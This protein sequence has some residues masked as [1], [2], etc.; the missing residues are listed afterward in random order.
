[1][2][3]LFAID[4]PIYG[5]ARTQRD[6]LIGLGRHGRAALATSVRWIFRLV[7]IVILVEAGLSINGAIIASIGASFV[8]ALVNRTGMGVLLDGRHGFPMRR[9]VGYAVPLFLASM[10]M[11]L[12]QRLDLFL[13]KIL[14]A[15]TAS[16]GAY[17]AAQNAA[18]VL[19]M[20]GGAMAPVI[21]SSLS[22]LRAS[23]EVESAQSIARNGLRA[24]TLLAPPVAL[25]A[26]SAPEI[27][28]TLFGP[29][30]EDGI[31]VLA[32]LSFSA[33]GL[34]FHGVGC[35]ALTASG[36]P[37]LV[38]ALTA[39]VPAAAVIGHLVAIPRYGMTGAAAVTTGASW[40][41][42]ILVLISVARLWRTW[43]SPATII[44]SAVTTAAVTAAALWWQ[45]SG[46]WI[47]VE[48]AVLGAA[49]G[50][51]LVALRE[52]RW[53]EICSAATALSLD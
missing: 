34:V 24:A 44:R 23:G 19:G 33:L 35:S 14:G 16:V 32:I 31:P 18:L 21:L 42:S 47:V 53:S 46:A 52:L 39:P 36:R 40:F 22:R 45:L 8:E 7:L 28:S 41:G 3:R 37:G 9:L 51:L 5:R 43:P 13:L 11:L 49:A 30:F 27:V 6:L 4:I 1:M 29:G 26:V 15:T 25:V 10:L 12:F 2:L 50:V 38:L 48:L 20:I 17:A